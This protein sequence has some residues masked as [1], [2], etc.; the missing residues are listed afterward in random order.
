M[1]PF[2]RLRI[3]AVVNTL[4]REV[5]SDTI[6]M[7]W[8]GSAPRFSLL[9]RSA[10]S[11]HGIP[12]LSHLAQ[13]RVEPP[14]L[15]L[16]TLLAIWQDTQARLAVEWPR[17]DPGMICNL[18]RVETACQFRCE[19]KVGR[20][21]IAEASGMKVPSPGSRHRRRA[22]WNSQLRTARSAKVGLNTTIL[23]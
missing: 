4:A 8:S 16:H 20:R 9:R 14:F 18:A 6:E 23:L 7:L 12:N 3:E 21:K 22:V 2:E 11:T 5:G 15:S 1:A 10:L 13:G 17:R 19:P